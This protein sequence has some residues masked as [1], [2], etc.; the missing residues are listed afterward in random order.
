MSPRRIS[1]IIPARDDA[2]ALAGTLDHL[3][4]LPGMEAAEI[5]VASSG[6]PQGTARAVGGRARLLVHSDGTRAGLMN[7]GAAVA[8]GET[9]FFLHA[10]SAP[11]PEALHLIEVAMS[12]ERVVG[13]AFEHR[14]AERDWRLG[15]ISG[16]NR[17]RY[18]VTRNYYGDQGIFVRAPVFRRLGGYPSRRLL[19]DLAF[20]QH[21]KGAGRTVL[22]RAPVETSGRRFLARGPWRTF[23]FTV[24][25]LGCHTM[26]LDTERYAER[27]RGPAGRPPGS[28]W[29]ALRPGRPE[30]GDRGADDR[31][32]TA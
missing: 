5:I 24:W 8:S 21:L 3:E 19:E 18:R 2:A 30:G 17:L 22:I 10:D 29:G 1:I 14:F 15:L 13:G 23:A 32:D 11:P 20:S 7:A 9:L 4:C 25:L 16:I 31:A 12:D 27:W 26:H 6:D 28:P